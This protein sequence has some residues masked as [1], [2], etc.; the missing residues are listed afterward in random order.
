MQ[1]GKRG[2]SPTNVFVC[3]VTALCG[4]AC[5]HQSGYDDDSNR[6]QSGQERKIDVNDFTMCGSRGGRPGLSV[7]MSP[8]VSVDV[9]EHCTMLRHWSQFVLSMSTDI[10]GHEAS[11]TSSSS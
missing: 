4:H 3:S 10:R 7:L 2:V 8:T 5:S 6:L 1:G 11:S 9:K